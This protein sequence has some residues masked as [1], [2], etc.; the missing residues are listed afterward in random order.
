MATTDVE[1][2]AENDPQPN[3]ESGF[4][5]KIGFYLWQAIRLPLLAFLLIVEPVARFVLTAVALVGILVSF[6]LEF[7]GAAPR[8]PFWL[9]FGMSVGCG[10][11]VIVLNAIIRRLAR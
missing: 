9:M 4:L 1:P 5:T 10:A 11:L 3:L 6:V 8:F 7:S 2:R